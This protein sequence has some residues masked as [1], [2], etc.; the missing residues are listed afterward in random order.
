MEQQGALCFLLEVN[1]KEH[2]AL[3]CSKAMNSF[4]SLMKHC[5]LTVFSHAISINW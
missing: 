4:Q 3:G 1:T 2:T 5:S